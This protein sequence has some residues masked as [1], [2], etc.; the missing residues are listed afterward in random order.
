MMRTVSVCQGWV[1][2]AGAPR[3]PSLLVSG[4]RRQTGWSDSICRGPGAGQSVTVPVMTLP[5]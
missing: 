2:P 4:R 5:A 3:Q 1:T